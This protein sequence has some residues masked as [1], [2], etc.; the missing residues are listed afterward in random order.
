MSRPLSRGSAYVAST[1]VVFSTLLHAGLVALGAG[2]LGAGWWSLDPSPIVVA[3]GTP[4]TAP[5]VRTIDIELPSFHLDGPPSPAA[6]A[7]PGV[8]PVRDGMRGASMP[9]PDD[10]QPGRGGSERTPQPAVNLAD[11]DDGIR[12]A[13]SVASHIDRDQIPRVLSSRSRASW[14]D[15]RLTTKPTELTF[16]ASGHG[17]RL[18]RRTPADHDPSSGLPSARAASDLGA[19]AL[20]APAAPSGVDQPLRDEGGDRVGGGYRS[21][22]VGVDDSIASRDHRASADVAFARPMVDEGPPSVPANLSGKPKD[23]LDSA[24]HVA[25]T[26]QSLID[27][28][29]AG[30]KPGV[31]PGGEKGGGNPGAGG[32]AG[33]G[34]SS[35]S[36]GNGDGE[37]GWS[38]KDK[39]LSTYRRRMLAK[40]YPYWENAFPRWAVMDMR[41]GRVIV[42]WEVLANG[43]VR[44]VRVTRPSGIDEFDR[45]CVAAVRRA[46]PFEPIPRNLGM[47]AMRWEITF[48][49]SNP[50]VR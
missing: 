11:R 37:Y 26:R 20:G 42:S 33:R 14:E 29:T 4:R 22:G 5:S 36:L 23:N 8:V 41:Q 40:L 24:Q 49:A 46:A 32:V 9:R 1:A 25:A 18:E 31:G 2:L 7:V 50:I 28:S 45:N 16:L 39:H 17:D 35:R 21:P 44:N 38:G 47:S 12:L 15:G 48:D 34:F 13:R 19:V 10:G 30:G 43:A 3:A 27:A 6:S